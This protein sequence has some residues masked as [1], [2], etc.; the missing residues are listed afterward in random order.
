MLF[1]RD[2]YQFFDIKL[3]TMIKTFMSILTKISKKYYKDGGPI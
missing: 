1:L 2:F 3:W